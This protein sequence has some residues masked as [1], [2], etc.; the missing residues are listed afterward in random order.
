MRRAGDAVELSQA[1]RAAAAQGLKGLIPIADGRPFLDYVLSGLA[2]CGF[3]QVCLVLG[4]DPSHGEVRAYYEGAGRPRR[5]TLGFVTQR[6][7]RGT[8]DAVLAAE[9]FAEEQ[10]VLMLNADNLYP[11]SALRALRALPRA[12]LAGFRRSTLLGA[13]PAERIL[14]FALIATDPEG[15]L[16]RIV[17][18]PAPEAAL[19]FGPDPLVSMNLW[20][21]PPTIYA[22]C[23]TVRPSPR[24]ELE[25][26][27]AIV[28]SVA[29]G[30]R[31]RVVEIAD[32]VLDLS[33]P[34]D[35][36]LVSASLRGSAASP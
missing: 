32:P 25:L 30:E 15:N 33:G 11:P 6:E 19:P 1:Q 28:T 23:R 2:D 4:A 34:A 5:L 29:Q 35:I 13:I 24:G 3:R 8:A 16:T 36:P 21:L 27:D 18:K 9:R 7:P 14:A 22:A 20:L 17:E 12:G 10:S 26:A 31:Y